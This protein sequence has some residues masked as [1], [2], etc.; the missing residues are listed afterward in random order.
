MAMEHV[1]ELMFSVAA[2]LGVILQIAQLSAR[3]K[4]IYESNFRLVGRCPS[5]PQNGRAGSGLGYYNQWA[6]E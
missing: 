6:Y 1:T 4:K 3:S 2:L 5:S